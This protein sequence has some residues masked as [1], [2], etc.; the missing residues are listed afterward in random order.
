MWILPKDLETTADRNSRVKSSVVFNLVLESTHVVVVDGIE[1]ITWGHN[2]KGNVVEHEFYGSR[3][4][5]DALS[6]LP[7]FD[8]GYVLITRDSNWRHVTASVETVHALS[9]RELVQS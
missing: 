8:Q 9:A 7:G 1:C 2:F 3:N 4:V 6:R 5:V